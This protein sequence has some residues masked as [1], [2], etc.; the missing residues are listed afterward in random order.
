MIGTLLKAIAYS[1]APK[2]TFRVL[3]PKEALQL[4]K[5]PYDLKYAYAPRLTAMAAAAV[6]LPLGILIGRELERRARRGQAGSARAACR[7]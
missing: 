3:H 5:L 2:T 7:C 1:R 6:A 4:K